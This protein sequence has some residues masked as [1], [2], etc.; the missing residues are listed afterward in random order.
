MTCAV[1][2]STGTEILASCSDEDVFLFDNV[3]HEDGKFLHRYSGHWYGGL[4]SILVYINETLFFC[5][6]I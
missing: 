5:T 6:V 4:C 2:N 3:N 1:Y